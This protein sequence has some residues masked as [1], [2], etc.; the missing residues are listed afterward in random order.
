M[1]HQSLSDFFSASF[2]K[3]K[4]KP[5]FTFLR[6][7]KPETHLTFFDLEQYSNRMASRLQ[8]MKVAKG[9]R[10]IL[11]IQ[12]SLAFVV[13]HLALQKLGAVSVPLN[14]DFKQSE[15]VYLL[16]DAQ[17]K[18]IVL[19]QDK[20]AFI[21]SLNPRLARL[22]LDSQKPFQDLDIWKMA[23]DQFSPAGIQE[24]DPGIIIYTSGT[25]GNPKGVILTQRNLISDALNIIDVWQINE[26][27]ILCHALPLFHVH[28]LCF[29]LHTALMAGSH[30]LLLDRFSPQNIIDILSK[31]KGDHVCTVFMAVPAMYAKLMQSLGKQKIDFGHLRLLTSGSAPLLP[32]DF[33]RIH[34]IF[35]KEPVER[36][37]MSETGMNFS[38][39]LE[40]K[41]KPGSIGLPMPGVKVRLVDP[42]TGEDVQSGQTGEIWLKGEAVTPGY[43]RKPE[44]TVQAF[45]G[46][47][48]KT[49]DLGHMD[50]DGYYFLT[51]R[52]KYIIISGGENISPKE[53]EAVINQIPDIRG[54]AVVG[55]PD[56]KWGEKV[57]AAVVKKADTTVNIE[58]IKSHCKTQLHSWKCPKEVIFVNE[59]PRNTMGK[60][61]IETV[62]TFF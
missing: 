42:E 59:L 36:E 53:I 4:Q 38:N 24:N 57:V 43:W 46:S 44:E 16:Q 50:A 45:D 41:R 18:V 27:D 62:K 20:V 11:F 33:K 7:G 21:K 51:D 8:S 49:G 39:P 10:V 29:A 34:N 55:I 28:G 47:W 35:G 9:D 37:G 60:V 2:L 56:E 5:A 30:V 26:S 52:L 12:K 22:A 3:Q 48:L 58:D 32:K 61:L 54:A 19:E 25:T 23:S 6:Q 15:M 14:P 1:D 17:A 40:G 13:V 31:K